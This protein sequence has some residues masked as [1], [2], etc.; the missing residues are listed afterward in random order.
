LKI[1]DPACGSAHFLLYCFDLLEAVYEEA[2]AGEP[3][4][5][6]E[7]TGKALRQEYPDLESLRRALPELILSYN[8]HGIDIDLR[9]CQ[10][11]ALALWL[12]AQRTYQRLG[13]RGADRP[14]ITKTNIVCAEPMPGEQAFLDQFVSG[15]EPK[16]I[17]QLVRVVFEKMKLAG[18]TG[19]LLKIEEEIAIAVAE[20]KQKWLAS[21]KLEQGRLFA[22]EIIRPKQQELG[23][24]VSGIT[25]ESFRE[26]A[27]DRIYTALQAYAEQAQNGRGYQRR[28][29]AEDAARGFAFV[30]L[31][32]KRYDVALMNP[33]FG[34]CSKAA[35]TYLAE[36]YPITKNDLYAEFVE[37][38]LGVLHEAGRLG[39]ITSRTGFFLGTFQGWREQLLLRTCR[40]VTMADLGA[41][42]LDTAMVEV[43]SYS[44]EKGLLPCTP[45]L[46]FRLLLAADKGGSLEAAVNGEKP[47][48]QFCVDPES[49]RSIETS[50]FAYWIPNHI[51]SLFKSLP[52]FEPAAGAVRCGLSTNDN[53]RF[54][55]A[56][57]EVPP[58]N[59]YFCYYP[60]GDNRQACSF[61]DPVVT[62][63]LARRQKG[64]R[65]WAPHVM[66][67]AS[68]PWFAPLTVMVNWEDEGAEIKEYA[69][70][71][72]NSP[73]RNVRSEDYYFRPGISWTRRAVRMIP[74]VIPGNSIPTASRYMAFPNDG[75]EM[76]ALGCMASNVASS[77]MRMF[78]EKF[79]F[80]NFLVDNV[81]SLPWPNLAEEKKRSIEMVVD[82]EILR[83][84]CLYS[85]HEPFHEF[86]MP[87]SMKLETTGSVV[88][89]YGS[90]LGEGLDDA[91]AASFGLCQDDFD[92][93]QRD[94]LEAVQAV[95]G[96]ASGRNIETDHDG[97]EGV[98]DTSPRGRSEAT[99]SYAVGCALG[100]W[101]VRLATGEKPAPAMP[102]PFAP[103]PACAPGMLQNEQGL[104]LIQDDVRRLQA[105]GEWDYPVEI[106]W[107][108]FLVDDAGPEGTQLHRDDIVRRVRQV[109]EVIRNG[110][111]EAVEQEACA[112]LGVRDLRDYFR[113]PASFFADHLKRY[114]KSRRQ[115]PIYWPLSTAS[116]SYTLWIYYHR[117]NDDT[118]Y[119]ALN[120]YVKPKID[121]VEKQ[122]RRIESELPNGTG[123]QASKLRS[124]FEDN[125]LLLEEL[126]ELRDELLEVA[127]LPYKPNL[128]DGVLITASPLWKLF[129]LPKWRNDL[130]ECWKKLA[131]GDYD[132]AHLAYSI[133]PDRV[134]EACKQDRS[135]AIAHGLEELC[136]V[137][138]KPTKRK[139]G[140]KKEAIEQTV[141][142]DEE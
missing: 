78:G 25:D 65:M 132:W 51:R 87:F 71:L 29:F 22:Y 140:R 28:L 131:A 62:A 97:D 138:V 142:G 10:I 43:A 49:F 45:A 103:L 3:S 127:G 42:V 119:T 34:A 19:S 102:G 14:K 68:Q 35:T 20:A 93:L 6:S 108:G 17:G 79:E 123:R 81:K 11:A 8:L 114:S 99:L 72:G 21:T 38:G 100:R 77:Y 30:D 95:R 55:R 23:F 104:P 33:P 64:R 129:R 12:R 50:P 128:N 4:V 137:A 66:A 126:R 98:L 121:E 2:W 58:E 91:I 109:F 135:I 67:G 133:W 75:M 106:P 32:R 37:R 69:R 107:D 60:T 134:R 61:D 117:L 124:A 82:R 116:G 57:W 113:K 18:E 89:D 73:S 53:P 110:Y 118:L 96:Y 112:I 26:E 76:L 41:D 125:K 88:F 84:R 85:G 36:S 70:L 13:L 1:L 86:L 139:R 16:V 9:A 136:E 94:L 90:L 40:L 59:Q 54:V 44:I 52:T 46:F 111:S 105:G 115:A 80:P 63:F 120:K 74:Y 56:F 39:A 15:L 31:C 101:D 47:S 48:I 122:L 92:V 5:A 83:R 24:D 27:E 7:T 130:E 141:V